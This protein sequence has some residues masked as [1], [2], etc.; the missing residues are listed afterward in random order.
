MNLRKMAAALTA[1]AVI[2]AMGAVPAAAESA[3]EVETG[4]EEMMLTGGW[5]IPGDNAVTEEAALALEKA[6]G[7]DGA[8]DMRPVALLG[9]QIVAGVNYCLLCRSGADA[10]SALPGYEIVYVYADL[11]GGASILETHRLPIGIGFEISGN[12]Q[13]AKAE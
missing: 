7:E 10:G 13:A 4:S 2:T 3:A 6:L 9:T 5:E 11:T 1:A 12:E 8:E